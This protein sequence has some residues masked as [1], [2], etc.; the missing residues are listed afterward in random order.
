MLGISASE[1]IWVVWYRFCDM[2]GVES[3]QMVLG[4]DYGKIGCWGGCGR[5]SRLHGAL[6]NGR[7]IGGRV[8]NVEQRRLCGDSPLAQHCEAPKLHLRAMMHRPPHDMMSC[9]T[10]VHIASVYDEHP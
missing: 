9:D 1:V 4:T 8:D 2:V 6:P 7:V 10:S 3:L 5:V